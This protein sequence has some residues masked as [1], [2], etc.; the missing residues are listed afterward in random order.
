MHKPISDAASTPETANRA[1]IRFLHAY[2]RAV[3]ANDSA[4]QLSH[5]LALESPS[6]ER[7]LAEICLRALSESFCTF[8]LD[9]LPLPPPGLDPRMNTYRALMTEIRSA[10]GET[11]AAE[12]AR[13]VQS[14]SSSTES[15]VSGALSVW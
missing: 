1:A 11:C 7:M 14:L 12:V 4:W 8:A 5:A 2:Q 10:A 15:V 6:R 9:S 3:N 13:R